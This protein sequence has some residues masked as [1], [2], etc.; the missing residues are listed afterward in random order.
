MNTKV[1]LA[2]FV[3]AVISFFF[4]WIVYGMLLYSFMEDR[5][6]YYEGLMKDPPVLW[7]IFVGGFCVYLLGA[8]IFD[9]WANIRSFIPGLKAGLWIGLLMSLFMDLYNYAFM[10]LWGFDLMIVDIVINTIMFG[11]I[12]G[13]IG[14]ILGSGKKEIL[15]E[16]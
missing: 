8:I 7:A 16:S 12:G 4:G 14:A 1:L 9:K 11:I 6:I 15:P 2:A 13:V 10:N 5:T 3:G